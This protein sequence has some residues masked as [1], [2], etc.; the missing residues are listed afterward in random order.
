AELVAEM[1]GGSVIIDL[2]A[3]GGGNCELTR[4]GEVVNHGGVL[5]D[6]P[7]N[8]PGQMGAHGS[9]LY[10]K[11]LLALLDLLVKDG[12]INI[13][14]EDEIINDSLVTH[15]GAIHNAGIRERLRAAQG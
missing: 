2:A 15:A 12:E 11:N 1:R 6:G 13:D 9:E 4:A 7:V 14:L 3:E 10:S 5:I 8:L